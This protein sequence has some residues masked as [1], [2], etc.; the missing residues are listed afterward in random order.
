MKLIP[1]KAEV[2]ASPED[3]DL[4]VRSVLQ[5]L[6]GAAIGD[7]AMAIDAGGGVLIMGVM[8][9]TGPEVYQCRIEAS[10]I[11]AEQQIVAGEVAQHPKQKYLA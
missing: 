3:I 2:N 6:T 4:L 5:E 10:N 1:W 8:E 9:E 7:Q 11:D